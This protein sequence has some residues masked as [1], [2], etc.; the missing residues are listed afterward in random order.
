MS[1]D[2]VVP[3]RPNISD[4]ESFDKKTRDE[5]LIRNRDEMLEFLDGLRGRVMAF[6]I[7]GIVT[8]GFSGSP[9][10]DIVFQSEATG[11]DVARTVGAL[12]FVKT[13]IVHE[14]LMENALEE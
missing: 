5:I 3:L 7:R 4:P 10:E 1:D 6:D 9:T 14:M 12:E 11:Y 8:V 2:K 13:S